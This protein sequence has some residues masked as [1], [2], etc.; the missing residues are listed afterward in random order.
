MK[1]NIFLSFLLAGL[2]LSFMSTDC[3]NK[4]SAPLDLCQ[5]YGDSTVLTVDLNNTSICVPGM[6]LTLHERVS[7]NRCP[8]DGVCVTAG[9]AKARISFIP[10][11]S[12]TIV[13]DTLTILGG[14]TGVGVPYTKTTSLGRFRLTLLSLTPYPNLAAPIPP[15][16]NLIAKIAVVKLP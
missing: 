13:Y 4:P 16:T 8:S 11:V 5:F 15:T 10:A 1:R 12:S 2:G 3:N 14:L 7:E 9:Q 6:N